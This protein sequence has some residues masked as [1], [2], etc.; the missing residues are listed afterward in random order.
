[1]GVSLHRKYCTLTGFLHVLPDFYV[2]GAAKCG[3]SSLYDYLIKHPS[4]QPVVIKEIRYFGKYYNRGLNW[5]RVC[6]PFRFQKYYVK[7][8]LKKDFLTGEATPR[9]LD[10]PHV[11]G[12]IKQITPNAKFIALLRN[13]IDR[14]YSHHNMMFNGGDETLSFEDAIK[15]EE[16]RTHEEFKKMENDGN[17]YSDKYFQQ[18]FLH[19]GIYVDKLK[20]WMKVFPKEQF[21]IIQSEEFFNNTPTEYNKILK[22]LGLPEWELTDYK[23]VGM[24]KYKSKLDPTTRKEL[25]EFFR[26]H[27]ER[28]Y[29][30][31]GTRFDWD[32]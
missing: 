16:E 20:Q 15:K 28:L 4:I 13:P 22:F 23:G 10:N 21:L 29:E 18:A 27:N 6:F 11:P 19:R 31:L 17:Y 5:Y 7:N 8:I 12:R 26:P 25:I 1:M 30:F 9:Y 3:T 32:Q 24:G 2:I 14:A